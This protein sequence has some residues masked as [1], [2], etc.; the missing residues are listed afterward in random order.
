[1]V[2]LPPTNPYLE[3]TPVVEPENFFGRDAEVRWVLERITA[4][5]PQCCAITGLR[6]IGKSSLLNFIAHPEGARTRYPG[7]FTDPERL[8]LAAVDLSL[9]AG[10]RGSNPTSV[11][12]ILHLMRT[13][14]R[15]LR[16]HHLPSDLRA[17]LQRRYEQA[18]TSGNW[19]DIREE[20]SEYL[21]DLDAQGYTVIFLLDELDAAT[22]WD[23]QVAHFLR[24][25][26][27]ETRTAYVTASLEPLF[28]LLDDRGNVSPLYNIFTTRPLGLLTASEARDLL[29][30][31]ASR[32]GVAWAGE[33]I[34]EVLALTGR[35]P[36][37]LKM[38]GSALW[39]LSHEIGA[40]ALAAPLVKTRLLPD[41][42]GLFRS[43][44]RHASESE[45]ETLLALAAG[46]PLTHASL[47]ALP[48]L[49]ERA[50]LSEQEGETL[51]GTLF[52]DWLQCRIAQNR[53]SRELSL[54]G[55]WILVDGERLQ[56]TPTEAR[57]ADYLF[58]HRGETCSRETLIRTVWGDDELKADSKALD[59][60]VQRLREKIEPDRANPRWLLTVRGEGYMLSL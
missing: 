49:R 46:K 52:T 14:N 38:A 51:F 42:E 36:D 56:L 29:A 39:E 37:L 23:P 12:V 22:A 44:W 25:L 40:A 6:R 43:I 35:H 9:V 34:D 10:E 30:A 54:D 60:A 53:D 13:L 57:L 11:A 24:A 47:S 19:T 58:S 27:M 59:T 3:R 7:Y 5:R 41:A 55:R 20:M 18:R 28:D 15:H 1:M 4:P 16:R 8:L 31:P 26:V 48:A 2:S 45:R 32:Q 17:S 21:Y 50:L 33:V